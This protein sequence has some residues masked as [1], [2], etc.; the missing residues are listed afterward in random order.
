ML[1][2]THRKIFEVADKTGQ[3]I[4]Q[5]YALTDFIG[6]TRRE[7][8]CV[9]CIPLTLECAA[10]FDIGSSV[11]ARNLTVINSELKLYFKN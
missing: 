3:D 10:S 9:A 4:D 7:N 11:F 8:L 1:E 5:F 6:M 2:R